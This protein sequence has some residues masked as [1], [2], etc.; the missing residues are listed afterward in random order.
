MKT[1]TRIINL[2]PTN[3]FSKTLSKIWSGVPPL[4]ANVKVQDCKDFVLHEVLDKLEPRYEKCYFVEYYT[5]SFGFFYKPS[6]NKVF[7][8]RRPSPG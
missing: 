6:K 1:D 7:V 3:K 4:L 8:A 5:K 2:V